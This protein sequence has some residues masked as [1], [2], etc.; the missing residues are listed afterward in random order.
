MATSE[1]RW[2]EERIDTLITLLDERP[3]LYNT[4]SKDYFNRERKKAAL[5][6]IAEVLGITGKRSKNCLED[7]GL[8]LSVDCSPAVRMVATL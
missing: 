1:H 7:V 3:C 5:E 2:T 4:K 6:E 8:S